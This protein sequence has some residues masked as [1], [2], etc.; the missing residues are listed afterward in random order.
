[1]TGD[2]DAKPSF[3]KSRGAGLLNWRNLASAAFS[4][5]L[6]AAFGWTLLKE[7]ALWGLGPDRLSRLMQIEFLAIHS[8][9]FIGLVT[10][11]RVPDWRFRTVQWA[12]F[13]GLLALYAAGAHTISGWPGILAF[14]GLTLATYLGFLLHLTGESQLPRL[15][16]RWFASFLLF[17]ACALHTRMPEEVAEWP[18][19][20]GIHVFGLLYFLGL[21]VLEW[22]GLYQSKW[23]DR[24][25]SLFKKG[26]S[27]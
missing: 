23:I 2:P 7:E 27:G 22:T 4:L 25:P 26:E 21:A 17:I 3:M 12:A 19:A 24:I 15:G 18:E 1:M 6:A 10:L 16:F 13:W 9:L 20:D 5:A 14:A 11:P 8:F